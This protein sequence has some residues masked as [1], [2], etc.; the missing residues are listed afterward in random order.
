[1][2]FENVFFVGAILKTD[3]WESNFKNIFKKILLSEAREDVALRRE[4]IN[5][6]NNSNKIFSNAMTG[7]TDSVKMLS[8]AMAKSMQ[9]MAQ[10]MNSSQP[11][12]PV[13]QV[14]RP[15]AQLNATM[16]N[17]LVVVNQKPT[18][19]TQ[20]FLELLNSSTGEDGNIYTY[21]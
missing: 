9:T 4:I 21:K 1:M 6:I 17:L 5:S 16:V 18:Q 8:E 10:C 7:I 11:Q 2:Y 20:S 3:F 15:Q 13:M 19:S 12:I 14:V